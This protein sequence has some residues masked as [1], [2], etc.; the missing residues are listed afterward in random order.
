MKKRDL[1]KKEFLNKLDSIW[2]NWYICPDPVHLASHYCIEQLYRPLER[3][4][5]TYADRVGYVLPTGNLIW[6]YAGAESRIDQCF[7]GNAIDAISVVMW[8][9]YTAW[10]LTAYYIWYSGEETEWH[11][12]ASS[13]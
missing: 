2:G 11:T 8:N 13:L 3:N 7:T 9:W 5:E 1:L 4:A 12:H 6:V 10:P